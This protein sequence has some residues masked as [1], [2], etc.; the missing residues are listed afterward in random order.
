MSHDITTA[1]GRARVFLVL[2]EQD[3]RRLAMPVYDA[4]AIADA[5]RWIATGQIPFRASEV[6]EARRKAFGAYLSAGGVYNYL[7]P[8]VQIVSADQAEQPATTGTASAMELERDPAR[9][10]TSEELAATLGGWPPQRMIDAGIFKAPEDPPAPAPRIETI[11]AE[12]FLRRLTAA[13]G[14]PV[15]SP[16]NGADAP[17][18]APQE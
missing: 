8:L 1:E 11:P 14:T 2:L 10:M 17:A 6:D 9:M 4:E 3:L 15:S 5:L 18:P 13:H 7:T 16:Q 12:E